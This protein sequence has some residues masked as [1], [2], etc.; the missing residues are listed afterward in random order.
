MANKVIVTIVS[1]QTVPNVLFIKEFSAA[2]K[3][4][5]VST[6]KMESPTRN[7]T[8]KIIETVKKCPSGALT[9]YLTEK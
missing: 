9:Y 7:T 6:E 2:D 4:I 3:Y 5:F 8:E 1:E